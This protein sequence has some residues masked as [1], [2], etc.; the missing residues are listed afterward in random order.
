MREQ[1][2]T[3]AALAEHPDLSPRAPPDRYYRDS[4]RIELVPSETT[5]TEGTMTTDEETQRIGGICQVRRS[6]NAPRT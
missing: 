2:A 3:D 1:G 6:G 4:G 5:E